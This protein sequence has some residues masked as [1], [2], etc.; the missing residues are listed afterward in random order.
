[1]SENKHLHSGALHSS[2]SIHHCVPYPVARL[3]ACFCSPSVLLSLQAWLAKVNSL[4][5]TEIKAIYQLL[6][7]QLLQVFYSMTSNPG[8][9]LW[10]LALVVS[11]ISLLTFRQTVQVVKWSVSHLNPEFVNW[12]CWTQPPVQFPLP[13]T[14][15]ASCTGTRRTSCNSILLVL[16]LVD[17]ISD[18][19]VPCPVACSAHPFPSVLSIADSGYG[20]QQ[21][22]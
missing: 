3:T 14:H 6:L 1:M 7:S 18:T 11:F 19:I 5:W 21:T 10:L 20:V 8:K 2:F 15:W 13:L 9:F 4:R 16:P 17:A 22:A 12:S